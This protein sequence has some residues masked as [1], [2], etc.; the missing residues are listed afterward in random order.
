MRY[1]SFGWESSVADCINHERITVRAKMDSEDIQLFTIRN[2]APVDRHFVRKNAELHKA[3]K[4][5]NHLQTLHNSVR[6]TRSFNKHVA[7]VPIRHL[8]DDLDHVICDR[9]EN[10]ICTKLFREF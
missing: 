9:I 3:A 1:D 6:M 4:L 5:A 10:H 8:L 7:A 2:D